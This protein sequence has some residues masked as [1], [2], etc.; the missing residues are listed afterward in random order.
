M[1]SCLHLQ[2]V[3]FDLPQCYIIC[4]LPLLSVILVTFFSTVLLTDGL[5]L[6]AVYNDAEKY[7]R[8]QERGNNRIVKIT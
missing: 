4:T 6:R 2:L 8:A 1:C 5:M 3:D 7:I